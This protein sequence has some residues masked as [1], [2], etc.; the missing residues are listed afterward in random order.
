[1]RLRLEVAVTIPLLCFRQLLCPGIAP[2]SIPGEGPSILNDAGNVFA[3][4]SRG[5][6]ASAGSEQQ[7]ISYSTGT[8]VPDENFPLLRAKTIGNATL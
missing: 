7:S 2:A 1:M 4:M 6:H 8:F 5:D 3:G